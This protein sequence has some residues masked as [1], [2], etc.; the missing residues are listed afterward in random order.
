MNP[1]LPRRR[2]GNCRSRHCQRGVSTVLMAVAL[3]MLLGFTAL[4]V[5]GSN[6]YVAKNELHNAADA[7]A[8]AGARWLYSMDGSSVNA[9][10]N[11]VAQDAAT[12]NASQGTPVEVVSVLRGHWSF[13]TRTFTPNASLSPVTLAGKTTAELD[14]DPNF[15]NAIEVVTARQTTPVEAFFGTVLGFDNYDVSARAVAYIGFAGALRPNDADQPIAMCKQA[16]LNTDGSYD[17]SVGRFIPEGDQTGGWTNFLHDTSGATN[18]SELQSLI[19]GDGNPAEMEFGEDIG[20][21]NG[22]VQSAFSALYDCWTE[23]TE[24]KRLWGLTLPVIDC[25]SGVAPQNPLVGAVELNIVW[26]VNGENKIDHSPYDQQ[27][28]APTE[29]T[30]PAEDVD[31]SSPGTWTDTS[32]SGEARWSNFVDNFNLRDQYDEP[33]DWR[34][35]S[36]YFLPSC[37]VHE[38]KGQTGGENYGILARIP[39]LVD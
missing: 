19:C 11:A 17:C 6:L 36:I 25:E 5:D 29:M 30:L 39:V 3:F 8:L 26:M 24:R 23:E 1:S 7:G 22:Q 13:A 35:K 21:N 15:I 34:Q 27:A 37:S 20:T 28:G 16:L 12:A 31:S 2:V 38:P 9:G 32:P 33:A 4:A 18:A 14:A 10:A